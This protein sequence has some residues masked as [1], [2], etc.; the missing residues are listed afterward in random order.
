M[1]MQRIPTALELKPGELITLRNIVADS[2]TPTRNISGTDRARLLQLEL[3]RCGM[4]G[5]M[6]TPAGRIVARL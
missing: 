3:I 6:A 4:G 2:F 1:T 5:V